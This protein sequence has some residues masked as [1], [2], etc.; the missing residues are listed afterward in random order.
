MTQATSLTSRWYSTPRT[1]AAYGF[2]HGEKP[3]WKVEGVTVRLGE[4]DTLQLT[5]ERYGTSNAMRV[6]VGDGELRF[7]LEDLV[8]LVLERLDISE[9]AQ[10]IMG[11]QTARREILD[12]LAAY[13]NEH[14]VEDA[15]RRYW[16]AKVQAAV[17]DK[18]LDELT[19]AMSS[20]ERAVSQMGYRAMDR[21]TYGNVLRS[22]VRGL[23]LFLGATRADADA[24]ADS[25]EANYGDHRREDL[26]DF[27]SFVNS[28]SFGAKDAWSEARDY[29]REEVK[30]LFSNVEVPE[31]V[32]DTDYG[33]EAQ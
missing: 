15:D 12:A 11:D 24:I 17:H 16:I 14:S 7:P 27:K 29:W 18:K 23:M 1:I 3:Y 20:I 6:E 25:I 13:Y 8:P 32:S 33:W 26:I 4:N 28:V 2:D 9:L 31:P 10:M 19:S 21:I 5:G 22:Q 30:A